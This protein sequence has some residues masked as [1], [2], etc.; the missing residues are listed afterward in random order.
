LRCRGLLA[1]YL[2]NAKAF[3][4][5]IV[6]YRQNY[7]MNFSFLLKFS[8]ETYS[9]VL[10]DENIF[11]HEALIKFHPSDRWLLVAQPKGRKQY[12]VHSTVTI[13]LLLAKQTGM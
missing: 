10:E 9:G 7:D 5:L 11:T 6:R 13:I 2:W 3:S 8:C 12:A 4:R 1:V